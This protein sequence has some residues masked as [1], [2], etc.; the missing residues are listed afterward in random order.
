MSKYKV[1][2]V[3]PKITVEIIADHLD[4]GALRNGLDKVRQG[5]IEHIKN[6]IEDYLPP[7]CKK[8]GFN[9]R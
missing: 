8:N 3:I 4:E 9:I 5:C 6:N 7:G 1:E 2:I